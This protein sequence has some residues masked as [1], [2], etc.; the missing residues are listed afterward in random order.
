MEFVVE[1]L[2]EDGVVESDE[3]G[4]DNGSLAVVASVGKF[5][6]SAAYRAKFKGKW[7]HVMIVQMTIGPSVKLVATDMLQQ[8]PTFSAHEALRVP[9]LTH[10]ADDTA[11]DGIGTACTEDS[12]GRVDSGRRRLRG[13]LGWGIESGYRYS[14]ESSKYNF[15]LVVADAD[16]WEGLKGRWSGS[17]L[18]DCR[19]FIDHWR[20][21]YPRWFH[22]SGD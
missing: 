21:D 6:S 3:A 2:A 10:G 19:R 8:F 17:R 13:D 14:W 11:D 22:D 16:R 9:S 12:R 18:D 1:S 20:L 15:G 5:L 7:T 4:L